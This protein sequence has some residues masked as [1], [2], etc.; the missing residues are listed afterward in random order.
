[1]NIYLETKGKNEY[2]E[3]VELTIDEEKYYGEKFLING[4]NKKLNGVSYFENHNNKF[5]Y[6]I[7]LSIV[8]GKLPD[9][10]SLRFDMK[11]ANDSR[12]ASDLPQP[13]HDIELF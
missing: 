1:M 7:L 13:Y 11:I 9:N 4:K 10:L 8:F 12:I 2:L 6:D 3:K 5:N